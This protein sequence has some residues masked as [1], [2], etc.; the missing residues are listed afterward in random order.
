MESLSVVTL[1]HNENARFHGV[2][3]PRPTIVSSPDCKK[4]RLPDQAGVNAGAWL[5]GGLLY[6][7]IH[8][9]QVKTTLFCDGT[10]SICNA[11]KGVE[12]GRGADRRGTPE[13][14][15]VKLCFVSGVLRR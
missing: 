9:T 14:A 12:G 10:G 15:I 5:S 8:V 1:S 13:S 3:H 6:G 2:P 4:R 11:V 7:A